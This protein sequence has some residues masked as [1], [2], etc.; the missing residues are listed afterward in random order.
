MAQETNLPIVNP[1]DNFDQ[2]VQDYFTN[3]F[4]APIKMTDQEYEAAKS[5]FLARTNS[6]PAAAALTAATIQAANELN[7]FILDVLDEFS[8]TAD[9]KSAVPTFL[10]MSR[11]GRSLLGYEANITPTENTARQVEA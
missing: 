3:Y 10:N 5:F 4:T 9:L 11:S 8:T 1:A 2:R 7:V 6:E